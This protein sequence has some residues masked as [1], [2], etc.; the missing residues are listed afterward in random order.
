MLQDPVRLIHHCKLRGYWFASSPFS[1]CSCRVPGCQ[2][3][4]AVPGQRYCIA[5]YKYRP[6][7][8]P[9]S[10]GI[11]D[12]GQLIL[13]SLLSQVTTMATLRLPTSWR[14]S[15]VEPDYARQLLAH[16]PVSAEPLRVSGCATV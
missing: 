14:C 10:A 9:C 1:S 15:V 11:E 7:S 6:E 16:L 3:Y 12:T 4:E 5:V 2:G 13:C 8:L